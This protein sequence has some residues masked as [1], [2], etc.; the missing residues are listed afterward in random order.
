MGSDVLVIG[1]TGTVGREVV[2]LL[3]ERGVAVRAT[4]RDVEGAPRLGGVR[5]VRVTQPDD[6]DPVIL[7]GVAGLFLMAPSGYSD[8]YAL[9]SPWIRAASQANVARIVLMT[10]Q[11]VNDAE[12]SPFRRAELELIESRI[13]HTI[14]RPN[15][16]MQNFHSYWGDQIRRSGTIELPAGDGKI[17]FIDARDIAAVAVAQL[18]A[19]KITYGTFVLTGPQALDHTQAARI[20]SSATGRQIHYLNT[21]PEEFGKTMSAANGMPEDYVRSVL[22]MFTAVRAGA[23]AGVTTHVERLTGR[24]ARSL[25]DYA[26]DYRESLT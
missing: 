19:K 26:R 3:R 4:T 12:Q 1:G 25:A 6:A 16:F 18:L 22:D 21:D 14:V 7:A 15:W 5:W 17:A 11:E 20:L 2:K 9:L 8:Q 23:A 10:A 13:P 24:P